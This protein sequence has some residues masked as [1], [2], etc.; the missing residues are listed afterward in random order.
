MHDLLAQ[1]Y[2]HL[3]GI[4]K[5]RWYAVISAWFIALSGWLVVY[6]LPD[7]YESSARVYVDTQTIL[8]P[9]L[10]GM[11]ATPNLQQ[12]VSIMSQTLLSRPNVERVMRLVDLDVKARNAQEKEQIALNLMKDISI[13][14]T[15]QNDLYRITYSNENPKLANNVVQSLLTIFVE[16]GLSDT[17]G[18][19]KSALR[20]IDEQIKEYEQKLVA[21]EQALVEFKRKNFS[22]LPGQG[23]DYFAKLT[24]TLEILKQAQLELQEAENARDAVKQQMADEEPSATM[25]EVPPSYSNPE[26]DARILALTKDLDNLRLKY[27]EQHPDVISTKRLIAQLE[28][29]KKEEAKLFKPGASLGAVAGSSSQQQL[30]VV[31]AEAEARAA[32][33]KARV[34]EYSARYGQ[35]KAQI[36]LIP[37]V[38][39]EYTQLNRDYGVNKAY[40]DNLLQRRE[41]AKMSGELSSNTEMVT[42]RIIDPPTLPQTP[43]SP[44]RL[45]LS[46][47]V[48]LGALLGGV[49]I[50]FLMSQ[51]RPTFQSQGE[52][53]EITGVPVLGTVSMIWTEQ[54][55]ARQK[56]GVYAFGFSF[57][58]LLGLYA[59]VLAKTL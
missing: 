54:E 26:I 56:K 36:N 8:R 32:S 7:R 46:S 6:E 13:V 45:L 49:G 53:W 21:G 37:Q 55:K 24:A 52:M 22:Q 19:T 59:A 51:I 40:Y 18:D 57:L 14:A 35:L 30:G 42:F 31:L 25:E 39:A 15:T 12:Q 2:S 50:A 43:T 34:A 48:F 47:L 44:N 29:R 4:W 38:E 58:F 10:S 9:L 27:T 41:S 16:S 11:T 5:Y 23:S 3:R 17:K 20:F 33:M 1:L 28:E